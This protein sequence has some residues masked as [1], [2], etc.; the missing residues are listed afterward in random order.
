MNFAPPSPGA[1]SWVGLLTTCCTLL[2][3]DKLSALTGDDKP[4]VASARPSATATPSS[5][6]STT[7]TITTSDDQVAIG[8][9]APPLPSGLGLLAAKAGEGGSDDLYAVNGAVSHFGF[10][11]NGSGFAV[12]SST[13]AATEAH[14]VPFCRV[15]R[16][17]G[18]VLE[19]DKKPGDVDAFIQKEDLTVLF[20]LTKKAERSAQLHPSTIGTVTA[21]TKKNMWK[22]GV[23]IALAMKDDPKAHTLSIG[24]FAL[25][26]DAVYPAVLSTALLPDAKK[27]AT[28]ENL[29]GP[30][31]S[32]DGRAIAAFGTY[33]CSAPCTDSVS[34]YFAS[35]D[36]FAA[37]VMNEQ[38]Y[39]YY[40]KK[41]FKK[42][43]ERFATGASTDPSW[44]LTRYNEA[45]ANALAKDE[46]RAEI[47]LQ[48]AIVR[49]GGLK[50]KERARKDKDFTEYKN[51]PWFRRLTD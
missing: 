17:G 35:V 16:G 28:Q 8:V 25:S 45:C 47:A 31:V 37:S 43:A 19:K 23:S 24:G 2:A 27:T 32:A 30:F 39:R 11:K 41:D 48:D 40:Q 3:C 10:L 7:A 14:G 46:R 36:R 18:L 49:G 42:A 44:E 13:A 29:A 33:V 4:P 9:A 6:P 12:C 50:I 26:E 20:P 22:Y 38:G 51:A 15:F 21:A 5:A 1:L 34:V